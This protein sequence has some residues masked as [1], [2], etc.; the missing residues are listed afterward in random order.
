[1]SS[2][3]ATRVRKYSIDSG[4]E[5]SQFSID[6]SQLDSIKSKHFNNSKANEKQL[7][8]INE[9]LFKIRDS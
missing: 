1:M 8:T 5:L 9:D 3:G 6:K 2:K 4:F 7:E